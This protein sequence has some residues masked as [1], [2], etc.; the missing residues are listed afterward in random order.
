M[1]WQSGKII[2]VILLFF[3]FVSAITVYVVSPVF[4]YDQQELHKYEKLVLDGDLTARTDYAQLI[5]GAVIRELLEHFRNYSPDR[6]RIASIENR[7]KM[8]MHRLKEAD[9]ALCQLSTDIGRF[10]RSLRTRLTIVMTILL[11]IMILLIEF[12][13]VAFNKIPR[14]IAV[15]AN[16]V[17]KAF[18]SM[19]TRT[20]GESLR[21]LGVLQKTENE[22]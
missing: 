19:H 16:Q 9:N 13:F 17:A 14:S 6:S 12:L 5:D 4:L 7:A 18:D 20:V 1:S 10:N 3:A 22:P 8:T 2:P 15:G 21:M 11:S